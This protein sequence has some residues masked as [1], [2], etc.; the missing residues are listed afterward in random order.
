MTI[1]PIANK[2]SRAR[3]FLPSSYDA[4]RYRIGTSKILA[5]RLAS[6]NASSISN[7]KSFERNGIDFSRLVL[8]AL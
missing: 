3:I 6:L 2:P 4:G 5:R 8:T 7:L 1:A